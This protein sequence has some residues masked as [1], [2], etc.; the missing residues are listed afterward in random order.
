MY[1]LGLQAVALCRRVVKVNLEISVTLSQ[2]RP[3]TRGSEAP[4]FWVPLLRSSRALLFLEVPPRFR[5]IL[6]A[7]AAFPLRSASPGAR[8]SCRQ[9]VV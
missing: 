1:L 6:V 9:G 3:S 8:H 4:A 5:R 2:G 7:P